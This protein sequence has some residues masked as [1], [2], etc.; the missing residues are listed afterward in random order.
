MGF[1]SPG[2]PL[3]PMAW[4]PRLKIYRN[5]REG[6]GQAARE[7][8]VLIHNC[9]ENLHFSGAGADDIYEAALG[10]FMHARRVLNLPRLE[11]GLYQEI[12]DLLMWAL[13]LPEAAL[14][15]ADGRPE[16]E[17]LT[18]DGAR[19]I[20][21]RLVSGPD[22]DVILEYKTGG[23]D[24]PPDAL[25]LPEH[26]AQLRRYLELVSEIR[27]CPAQGNLIYLDRREVY[28]VTL[29]ETAT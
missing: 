15:F 22:G 8:G 17:I 13:S 27:R 23:L 18:A 28:P 16:Q 29:E 6:Q 25:P 12:M 1:P 7:R 19:K 24:L 20:A 26:V 5:A 21:D 14:W 10:A 3:I 2:V 9:L 11:E 4:L